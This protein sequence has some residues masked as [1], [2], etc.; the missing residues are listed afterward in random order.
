MTTQCVDIQVASTF[1]ASWVL[2]VYSEVNY[3]EGDTHFYIGE[4]VVINEIKFPGQLTEDFLSFNILIVYV[5]WNEKVGNLGNWAKTRRQ[6][7]GIRN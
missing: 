7:N 3:L 2:N 5:V 6:S 1:Q 4:K